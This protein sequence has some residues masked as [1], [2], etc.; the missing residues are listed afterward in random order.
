V[1]LDVRTMSPLEFWK[2]LDPELRDEFVRELEKLRSQEEQ[3]RRAKGTREE[4][5][6]ERLLEFV[7]APEKSD[8]QGHRYLLIW[9]AKTHG[10]RALGY[11]RRRKAKAPSP[12]S[13]RVRALLNEYFTSHEMAAVVPR[14]DKAIKAGWR[15]EWDGKALLQMSGQWRKE[16]IY[17]FLTDEEREEYSDLIESVVPPLPAWRPSWRFRHQAATSC[18][19]QWSLVGMVLFIPKWEPPDDARLD[20]KPP[21]TPP[22]LGAS[23]DRGRGLIPSKM[24]RTDAMQ[25]GSA[26][27]EPL[28]Q[29]P[30]FRLGALSQQIVFHASENIDAEETPPSTWVDIQ[31]AF[32]PEEYAYQ[33]QRV[34][35]L[36]RMAAQASREGRHS[37]ALELHKQ[38]IS[39]KLGGADWYVHLAGDVDDYITLAISRRG[40]VPYSFEQ[41]LPNGP[42]VLGLRQYEL[43]RMLEEHGDLHSAVI[44][45]GSCIWR[46]IVMPKNVQAMQAQNLAASNW[47]HFGP[48][49]Q[50]YDDASS[51]AFRL[52]VMLSA[53]QQAVISNDFALWFADGKVTAVSLRPYIPTVCATPDRSPAEAAYH[54]GETWRIS[55]SYDGIFM[56]QT[57]LGLEFHGIV[58][59]AASLPSVPTRKTLKVDWHLVAGH[60]H[61]AI[62]NDI[63]NWIDFCLFPDGRV[64]KSRLCP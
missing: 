49:Q 21:D 58:I 7:G 48:L 23:T 55:T 54:E 30:F 1:G 45:Y 53:T 19:A 3:A 46:H 57:D 56:M 6:V 64:A 37:E 50:I 42:G 38:R 9:Y 60:Q 27:R 16:F 18:L 11:F 10:E 5:F 63:V 61:P 20:D 12:G 13:Q 28:S 35:D 62:C 15:S 47:A 31:H 8:R 32:V 33:W 51:Y 17:D 40:R 44:Q 59:R 52:A 14:I 39:T 2:G 34:Q 41:S 4:R 24:A 43:G 36:D 29:H 25:Q 26:V 22:A